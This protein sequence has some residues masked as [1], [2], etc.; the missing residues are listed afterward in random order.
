MYNKWDIK[1]SLQFSQYQG[2]HPRIHE[3]SYNGALFNTPHLSW[4]FLNPSVPYFCIF[5]WQIHIGLKDN[6]KILACLGKMPFKNI[7]ECRLSQGILL[8]A[9][10]WSYYSLLLV[11]NTKGCLFHSFLFL[12]LSSILFPSIYL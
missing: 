6:C 7:F 5:L 4:C 8:N 12:T 2:K 3:Y 9:R 10:K 11:K 1:K